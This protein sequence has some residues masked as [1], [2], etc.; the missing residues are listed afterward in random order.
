MGIGWLVCMQHA[1][2]QMAF[3]GSGVQ[4]IPAA[5][6]LHLPMHSAGAAQLGMKAKCWWAQREVHVHTGNAC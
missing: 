1:C 2:S 3:K 4:L 5:R 6:S